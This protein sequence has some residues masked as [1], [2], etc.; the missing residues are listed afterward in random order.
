MWTLRA[1]LQAKCADPDF[2]GR[3]HEQC[4]ICPRTV[5]IISTIRERG[6]TNEEVARRSGVKLEHLELL[7][8]AD[9]CIVDDVEELGRFLNLS[10]SGVCKKSIRT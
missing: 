7:E 6:L 8:S 1:Y 9:Q 3:Y 10:W 5:L 2:L 4:T